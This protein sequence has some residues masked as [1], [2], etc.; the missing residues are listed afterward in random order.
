MSLKYT[1]KYSLENFHSWYKITLLILKI[2]DLHSKDNYCVNIVLTSHIK[3]YFII[4]VILLVTVRSFVML[5]HISSAHNVHPT[6]FENQP[7]NSVKPLKVCRMIFLW[8]EF[9]YNFLLLPISD[10]LCK[11]LNNLM[12]HIKTFH[13]SLKYF[14]IKIFFSWGFKN[15]K[16]ISQQ[17]ILNFFLGKFEFSKYYWYNW[18]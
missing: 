18:M 13:N 15:I 7:K 6:D 1:F 9:T 8:K 3:P 4:F 17:F 11:V 12:C 5:T 16:I 10:I 14:H 2:L